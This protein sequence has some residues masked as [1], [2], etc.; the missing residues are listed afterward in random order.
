MTDTRE[1]T[2][3]DYRALGAFRFQIRRFLAFSESAAREEGL[4]PQ[5]HQML[6]AIRAWE[7]PSA[8]PTVGD[9]ADHL[10]IR[11]HSAVGLLDRLAARGL[12]ERIRAE[13]DRRQVQVRLTD[14]GSLTLHRLSR[15]HR[16]ELRQSGPALVEVLRSLLEQA[17]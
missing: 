1:L 9:L 5:Q 16:E 4:E 2:A 14:A 15:V 8:A 12:V 11:H 7:D 6:L 3:S 17:A 13:D 10:F